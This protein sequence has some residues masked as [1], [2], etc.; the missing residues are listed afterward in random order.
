MGYPDNDKIIEFMK[1]HDIHH[2]DIFHIVETNSNFLI[3]DKYKLRRVYVYA[4]PASGISSSVMWSLL[5]GRYTVILPVPKSRDNECECRFTLTVDHG[6]FKNAY[7]SAYQILNYE[8]DNTNMIG[9]VT[10][11]MDNNRDYT[12]MHYT[13][14]ELKHGD[15]VVCDTA[16]GFMVG[17]VSAI[18]TANIAKSQVSRFVIQKVDIEA[19]NLMKS[20]YEAINEIYAKMEERKKQ[21]ENMQTFEILASKDETMAQLLT[22]LKELTGDEVKKDV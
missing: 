7:S 13:S 6:H 18:D 20:K 10:V 21:I 11:K 5:I 1:L 3:D 15:T 19:F 4:K 8:E 22:N 14:L 2:N 9:Y 12:F 17:I 16:K